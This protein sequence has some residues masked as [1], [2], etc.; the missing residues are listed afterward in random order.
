MQTSPAMLSCS[1][2]CFTPARSSVSISYA[3]GHSDGCRKAALIS[4]TENRAPLVQDARGVFVRERDVADGVVKP[5]ITFEET[6]AVVTEL[7]RC[8]DNSANHSVQAGAISTA[9]QDTDTLLRHIYSLSDKN[10]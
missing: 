10:V 6:Y 3:I 9:G 8:L 7:T 5:L 1:Q 2:V 4:G